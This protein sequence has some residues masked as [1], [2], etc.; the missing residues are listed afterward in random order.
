M[1]E[2]LASIRRQL[3]TLAARKKAR[4]LGWP[5]AWRPTTVINPEDG[6]PF[7]PAGARDF[8]ARVLAEGKVS[9]EEI[10]LDSPAGAKGYVLHIPMGGRTLYVKLQ[11]GSGQI[12]GRSFH[13]SR[14]GG[15]P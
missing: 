5:R 1:S 10:E 8:V 14:F 15:S 13:Y 6:N 12:I 11:L 7:T 4:V 9:L 2:R 3:A